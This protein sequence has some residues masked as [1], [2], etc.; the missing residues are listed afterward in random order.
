MNMN[1]IDQVRELTA[2][3]DAAR[4]QAI[5]E[6]QQRLARAVDQRDKEIARVKD[7]YAEAVREI[8]AV[9]AELGVK[10]TKRGRPAGSTVDQSERRRAKKGGNA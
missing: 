7:L 3:A 10:T 6:C 9:L 1:A 5:Q 8:N 2:K 4:T